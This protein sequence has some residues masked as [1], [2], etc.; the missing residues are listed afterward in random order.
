MEQKRKVIEEKK[1]YQDVI[2][3]ANIIYGLFAGI[4]AAIICAVVWA[5]VTVVTNYQIGWMAVGLGYVVGMAVKNFGRGQTKAY[6]LTGGTLALLGCVAG[7]IFTTI[8]LTAQSEGINIF[9]TLYL[10][11]P[12]YWIEVFPKSIQP[13]D[14]LF[15][16]IAIYEGFKFSIMAKFVQNGEQERLRSSFVSYRFSILAVSFFIL[17]LGVSS[18]KLMSSGKMT[19]HYDSGEKSSEGFLSQGKYDGEWTLWYENGDIQSVLNYNQGVLEGLCS[20]WNKKG[21]LI[22]RGSYLKGIPHGTWEYFND[23]GTLVSKGDY[24]YDRLNGSWSY[25]FS[26]KN[27][28]SEGSF[29]RGK[30]NGEWQ[31]WHENGKLAAIGK[32]HEDMKQGQWKY[33]YSDGKSK[34]D[35]EYRDNIELINNFWTPDGTQKVVNG[36]GEYIEYYSD[37]KKMLSG[38][39]T[40]GY[41]VGKWKK[42][43][44]QNQLIEEF[45]YND[46]AL[47]FINIW[48]DDGSQLIKDGNGNYVLYS[49]EICVVKG[50]YKNGLRDGEWNFY[51]NSGARESVMIYKEGEAHGTFESWFESGQQASQSNYLNGKLDG[52]YLWYFENGQM[53][54][55]AIF[56]DNKKIG[57]QSFWDKEGILLKEEYY[58][59]GQCINTVSGYDA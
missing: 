8:G 50:S 39:V 54:S 6:A 34:M 23:D 3:E 53:S 24:L 2:I 36:D 41:K 45:V 21:K 17:I 55:N 38:D 42:W 18:L 59:D 29:L 12:M 1:Y 47:N 33:W 49:Q 37:G 4:L 57:K 40:G 28:S 19:Y 56:K 13:M 44:P 20:S 15:Y 52:K 11:D 16:G 35:T 22:N 5:I 31:Y 10:V 48:S 7:N 46:G 26:N 9:Q 27:K 14:F 30:L 25:W 58:E 43:N 51:Y 32:Y